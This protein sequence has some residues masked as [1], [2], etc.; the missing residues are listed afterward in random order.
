M[1]QGGRSFLL[2][3]DCVKG[4]QGFVLNSVGGRAVDDKEGPI[5]VKNV[6]RQRSSAGVDVPNSPTGLEVHDGKTMCVGANDVE[7]VARASVLD[8]GGCTGHSTAGHSFGHQVD[9]S[10]FGP[11]RHVHDCDVCSVVE[12]DLV[13]AN[14]HGP[15]SSLGMW[16]RFSEFSC[17]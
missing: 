15:T 9:F 17:L 2:T 3:C 4:G 16:I 14:D 1:I 11:V 7:T 5:G 6:G 10:K 13:I 8:S 12:K